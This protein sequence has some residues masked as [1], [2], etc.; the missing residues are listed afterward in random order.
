MALDDTNV[1]FTQIC[2]EILG[3]RTRTSAA[4]A[5]PSAPPCPPARAVPAGALEQS[6]S[7]AFD[8]APGY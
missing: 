2:R 4:V 8:A 7:H 5:D 3:L 6:R 1:R